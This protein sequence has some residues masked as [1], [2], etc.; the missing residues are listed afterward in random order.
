ME[1]VGYLKPHLIQEVFYFFC[2]WPSTFIKAILRFFFLL[3]LSKKIF[4]F[5]LFPPLLSSPHNLHTKGVW[6]PAEILLTHLVLNA[7]FP[8]SVLA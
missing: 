1:K 2:P 3:T 8:A 7:H 5:F 6:V 4:I